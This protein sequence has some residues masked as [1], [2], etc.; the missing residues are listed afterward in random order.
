MGTWSAVSSMPRA[1][2]VTVALSALGAAGTFSCALMILLE[3]AVPRPA[4]LSRSSNRHSGG[5]GEGEGGRAGR[6]RVA[7]ILAKASNGVLPELYVTMVSVMPLAGLTQVGFCV[8][9]VAH[10][11]RNKRAPMTVTRVVILVRTSSGWT[12]KNDNVDYGPAQ[13]R[14]VMAHAHSYNKYVKGFTSTACVD[15]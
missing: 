15:G 5:I 11:E 4:L 12:V 8:M 6:R 10:F 2:S 3:T 13:T 9:R 14:T 7:G 1:D